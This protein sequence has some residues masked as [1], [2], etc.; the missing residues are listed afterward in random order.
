MYE[1]TQIMRQKDCRDFALLL[2]RLREGHHTKM[3]ITSLNN[4][5]VDQQN[6]NYPHDA[7]HLFT[8]N[9]RVNLHNF[10][11]L[12]SSKTP[13]HEVKS[14]DRLVGTFTDE[15]RKN[16]LDSFLSTANE[17]LPNIVQ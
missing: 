7:P 13:V 5:I 14:I 1:L 16:I 3:D 4:N 8:T 12:H 9:D 10:S 2:I 15:L 17:Q 11:A 6:D